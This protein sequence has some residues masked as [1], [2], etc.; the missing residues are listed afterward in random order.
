MGGVCSVRRNG[1]RSP[2]SLGDG[3]VPPSY[4]DEGYSYDRYDV[5]DEEEEEDG[6]NSS[7]RE[8]RA[9]SAPIAGSDMGI[10]RMVRGVR[11]S[12]GASTAAP[13][14]L[15]GRRDGRPGAGA[16]GGSGSGRAADPPRWPALAEEHLSRLYS[17]DDGCRPCTNGGRGLEPLSLM[18]LCVRSICR[19][20]GD[21]REFPSFLPR[22]IVDALLD[23][24][25]QHRA[26]SCYALRA[27][28][29]CEVTSLALG[30]CRGVRNGWVRELLGDTPCGRFIVKLDLSSCTGLTDTG[31]SE[32]P[33]LKSLESASLRHCSGL[34]G[35]ATLCLSNSP[36]LETL[37]LAHC[38]LLDD[39][40]VGNL[41]G[42]SR[43]R[44]LELE[45][46]ENI[47]DEGLLLACRLPSLTCLNASRCHG[48]TVDGL[49]GLGQAAGRLRR[50][51]LGW[52]MGLSMRGNDAA[53]PEE[54]CRGT[55]PNDTIDRQRGRGGGQQTS[56][57]QPQ[58]PNAQR[59]PATDC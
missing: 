21:F 20:L 34:G 12:S 15:G 13:A 52:C 4:F 23:S 37:S 35:E 14:G 16:D 3:G 8:V 40:A 50:L 41:V 26:L 29:D 45:G 56:S 17:N 33:A 24:L 58:Q 32:L 39:A 47:S 19:R 53:P 57:E 59:A 31:L 51:N 54:R 7:T 44:Y 9:A 38:P 5:D 1:D 43:L 2:H 22:E 6:S 27:F 28:R 11:T 18:E 25:T 42:L 30:D 48:I 55:A 46:C 10:A 36:A 49:A